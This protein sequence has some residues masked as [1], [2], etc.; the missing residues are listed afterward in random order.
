MTTA[1]DQD[2][3]IVGASAAGLSTA[4]ALRRGGHRGRLTLIDAE[5]HA[6]YDRPPLS[7]QFLSGSWDATRIALR[8]P[9]ALAELDAEFVLGERACHLDITERRVR[10]STGR[11]VS[12]DS[13]VIATG[14]RARRLTGQDAFTGTHVLRSIDDAL[15]LRNGLRRGRRLV[16]VGN[17]VL[18]SEVAATARGLGLAVSLVGS[19]ELPMAGQ[20]GSLGA[21]KLAAAH[22][23]AGVNLIGGH[24]AQ[25]LVGQ[26][27][28]VTGVV[29]DTGEVLPAD[30]VV[31]AVGSEPATEWLINSG[32]ELDDGVL[33][34]AR[35]RAAEGVWAVGDVARWE[36]LG[37]GEA[38]RLE[39]RT[40]A[41]EQ[42]I[43]V[44]RDVLGDGEPYLPL[45]SFWTDQYGV[46]I[47]VYGTIPPGART[48]IVDGDVL[49]GRFVALAHHNDRLVGVLGWGM[50]KQTR[51]RRQELAQAIAA[52]APAPSI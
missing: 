39:N 16:V 26:A 49:D 22:R 24:R 40:N 47:Q 25:S 12:A 36:H 44:A 13:V 37:L 3:L 48:E 50:P 29:L 23:A 7:K 2:I 15:R 46:K 35:C 42:A 28:Q 10:T 32:L 52:S 34:D 8:P 38:I 6:P 27:G 9:E 41:T 31:V 1:V 51:L 11:V 17:G 4:E 33:C 43:A 21:S 45:P 20:L 5:P 19:A 14:V 30:E 18:G